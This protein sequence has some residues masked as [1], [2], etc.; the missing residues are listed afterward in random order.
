MEEIEIF[1]RVAFMGMALIMTALTA[2]SWKRTGERKIM[3]AAIG[4]GVFFAEGAMLVAGIFSEDAEAINTTLAL[5]GLSFLALV[6]L[7]LSVLKR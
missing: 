1:L 2:A 7:Y 6:F 4:F 3:L 5:V